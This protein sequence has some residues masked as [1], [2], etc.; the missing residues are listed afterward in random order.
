MILNRIQD[1]VKSNELSTLKYAY[2]YHIN[3]LYTDFDY[4][5]VD[6]AQELGEFIILLGC[7]IVTVINITSPVIFCR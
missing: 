7:I 6:A 5:S 2:F 4:N 1:L 3:F